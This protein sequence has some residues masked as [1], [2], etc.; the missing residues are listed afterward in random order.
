MAEIVFSSDLTGVDWS[1]LKRALVADDFDNL[2]SP[3]QYWRS[4][5][6]SH[7]V[8]FGRYQGE[9]VANGRILSDGVC[10]AYLVDIW[11]ATPHRRKGVGREVVNRLLA[12]VPGQH[13]GLFTDEMEA[14][15]R[16]LGFTPQ[17]GG[18]SKVVGSWLVAD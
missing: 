11:T 4:H 18:M 14:F 5:E 16:T 7:A 3:D 12:T 2:R 9:F 15:Y 17:V 6:N 1:A 13:V 10:N 8:V